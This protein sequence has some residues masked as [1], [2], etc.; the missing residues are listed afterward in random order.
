MPDSSAE[1]AAAA[2]GLAEFPGTRFLDA[3]DGADE[4]AD[5]EADAGRAPVV[6]CRVCVLLACVAVADSVGDPVREPGAEDEDTLVG[7]ESAI[8]A[9]LLP[10]T[11]SCRLADMAFC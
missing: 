6:F 7:F 10:N 3:S 4:D 1:C 9:A 8:D 2:V 11:C 5:S